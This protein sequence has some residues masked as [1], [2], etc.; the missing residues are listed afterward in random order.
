MVTLDAHPSFFIA[1]VYYWGDLHYQITLGPVRANRMNPVKSAVNRNLSYTLHNDSPVVV[2]GFLNGRNTFIEIL[3][4]A[5]N[6]KTIGGRL[7]G[8]DQRVTPYQA[9]AGL[10]INSAWQSKS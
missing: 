1:Q 2:A 7:L 10:T 5:V 8:A 3:D 6:R 9:L 4:A